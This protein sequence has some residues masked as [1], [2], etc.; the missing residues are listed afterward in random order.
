MGLIYK[1]FAHMFQ[2]YCL[3]FLWDSECWEEGLSLIPLL[4]F[5]TLR[6]TGLPHLASIGE[7]V[8]RVLLQ[9]DMTGLVDNHGIPP[10]F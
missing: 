7:Y 2:L 3:V 6:P 10:L 9:L 1:S 4:A 5:W 8:P